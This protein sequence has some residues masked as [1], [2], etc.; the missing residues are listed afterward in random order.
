MRLVSLTLSVQRTRL[1]LSHT[2][3][4]VNSRTKLLKN[5]NRNPL[6]ETNGT[7][8]IPM[9]SFEIAR[10][11]VLYLEIHRSTPLFLLS[12]P[13]RIR[14]CPKRRTFTCIFTKTLVKI[15]VKWFRNFSYFCYECS[16]SFPARWYCRG[17][18]SWWTPAASCCE[19]RAFYPNWLLDGILPCMR[20][21]IRRWQSDL[22]LHYICSSRT[23]WADDQSLC[24][25]DLVIAALRDFSK[26]MYGLMVHCAA[27]TLPF[28]RDTP[29]QKSSLSPEIVLLLRI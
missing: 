7:I 23:A 15:L 3:T 1:S 19:G 25:S 10:C 18:R 11:V 2:T 24:G 27:L 17:C 9:S 14:K 26:Q 13:V 22:L 20:S 12:I 5:W 8:T 28:N 21:W 4:Q 6:E 16:Y 29:F